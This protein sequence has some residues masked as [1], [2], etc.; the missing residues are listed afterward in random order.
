M[1]G[2]SDAD[3]ETPAA[4]HVKDG[5]EYTLPGAVFTIRGGE[6]KGWWDAENPSYVFAEVAGFNPANGWLFAVCYYE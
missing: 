4:L 2:I 6:F 3:G 5:E 1:G